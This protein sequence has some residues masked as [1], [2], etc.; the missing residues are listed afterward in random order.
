MLDEKGFIIA[1]TLALSLVG[2]AA[3]AHSGATG[4][5][6]ERME[7]MKDIAGHMKRIG[8]MVKGERDYDAEMAAAAADA[9]AGHARDMPAL[10]PEGSNADPSEAL[11]VIWT[12]WDAFEK[13]AGE[14]EATA[15]ALSEA[16]GTASNADEI[17]T[18]FATVGK[19]C[20]A[21]HQD[22][23]KSD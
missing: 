5:V 23:R 3:L 4:I 12:Q 15:A 16:A 20:A 7:S 13:S 14:L 9:I 22:F 21:C 18:Q 19:A 11:P 6:A 10:F 8:A 17:R 1:A 2:G